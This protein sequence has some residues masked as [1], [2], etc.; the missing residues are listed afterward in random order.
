MPT[1]LLTD[2]DVRELLPMLECIDVMAGA[3]RTVAE[4]E[5]VLPLRTVLRVGDTSN[6]FLSM[7]AI[8]GAG[9][10]DRRLAPR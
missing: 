2:V 10:D 9:A 5:A 7:P 3:L 8:L 1:L 6:V 4:G